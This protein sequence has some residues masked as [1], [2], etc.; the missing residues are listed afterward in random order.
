[1]IVFVKN[2]I[3]VISSFESPRFELIDLTLQIGSKQVS[4]LACYRPPSLESDFLEYLSEARR[5]QV[6][7]VLV[8]GDLNYDLLSQTPTELHDVCEC[9]GLHNTISSGTR[10]NPVSRV[11]TLLDV[12][13]TL[14]LNFFIS[15][16]VFPFSRSDHDLVI[17][18]FDFKS[19]KIPSM[20]FSSRCLSGEKLSL[21]A[22]RL[23]KYPFH[24]LYTLNDVELIW[25]GIKQGIMMVLDEIAPIKKFCTKNS[26]YACPW[27]D[28]KLVNLRIH[29]Q[30]LFNKARSTL[31]EDHWPMFRA[32]RKL[33]EARKL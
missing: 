17:S 4:V 33:Y 6:D 19:I 24:V 16:E 14:C 30:R 12:I 13:L 1:M 26:K 10:F 9:I 31:G 3:T 11:S 18:I 5:S 25:S 27:S 23:S 15:S 21:L 20:S 8:V 29:K 28:K 22:E 7:D 2:N 32:A